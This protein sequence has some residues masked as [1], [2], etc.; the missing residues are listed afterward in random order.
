[1]ACS[2]WD[3]FPI[4]FIISRSPSYNMVCVL[5]DG[6]PNDNCIPCYVWD[7]FPIAHCIFAL[8]RFIYNRFF[9]SIS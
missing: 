8:G 9:L 2:L 7:G 4:V 5:W 6:F 3:G 1:M